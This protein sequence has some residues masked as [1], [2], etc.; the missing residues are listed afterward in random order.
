LIDLNHFIYSSDKIKKNKQQS[1]AVLKLSVICMIHLICFIY[2]LRRERLLITAQVIK[3]SKVYQ[4]QQ[5]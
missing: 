4:Q 1:Y 2:Y 3:A 5:M